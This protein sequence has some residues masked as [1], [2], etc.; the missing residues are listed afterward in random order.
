MNEDDNE[1]EA[2]QKLIDR[3][4]PDDPYSAS[5]YI[6]VDSRTILDI[7]DDEEIISLVQG[8]DAIEEDNCDQDPLG[9]KITAIEAMESVDKLKSFIMQQEVHMDISVNFICEL[10]KVKRKLCDKIVKSKVQTDLTSYLIH[11]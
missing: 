10:N 8:K 11:K 1:N 7:L 9:P 4:A 2:I 6:N 5:E 3:L